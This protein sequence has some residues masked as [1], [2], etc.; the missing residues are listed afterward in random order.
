ME[1]KELMYELIEK[2]IKKGSLSNIDERELKTQMHLFNS[3]YSELSFDKEDYLETKSQVEEL[4]DNVEELQSE[5][6][7]SEDKVDELEREIEELKKKGGDK[8]DDTTK[9]S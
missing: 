5:L 4:E 3:E 1:A 9:Q 2:L 7:S 6:D 8:E